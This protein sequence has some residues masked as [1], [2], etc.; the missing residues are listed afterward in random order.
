[1]PCVH[2]LDVSAFKVCI[3]CCRSTY[4][5]VPALGVDNATIFEGHQELARRVGD[6]D[7]AIDEQLDF[8]VH[9]GSL[10]AV[11]FGRHCVCVV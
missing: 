6:V 4:P 5:I 2:S 10:D 8:G 7:H 3:D 1:M 9:I 11:K